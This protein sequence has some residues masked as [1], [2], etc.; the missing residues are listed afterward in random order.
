VRG[1]EAHILAEALQ[2]NE[3]AAAPNRVPL[4]LEGEGRRVRGL[5][6]HALAGVLGGLARAQQRTIPVTG[7]FPPGRALDWGRCVF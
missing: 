2:A 4:S 1:L 7:I 3:G 6:A 5:E